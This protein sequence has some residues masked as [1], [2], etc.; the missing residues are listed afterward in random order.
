MLR[1]CFAAVVAATAAASAHRF[2]LRALIVISCNSSA[3]PGSGNGN[4]AEK[5]VSGET[6]RLHKCTLL[7][8]SP[9]SIQT[10]I[11]V[12]IIINFHILNIK[13]ANIERDYQKASKGDASVF[14]FAAC[15]LMIDTQRLLGVGRERG[16][17]FHDCEYAF[18][19][20][21]LDAAST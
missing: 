7:H 3:L 13:P 2:K 14:H 4:H 8:S 1:L 9:I 16:K 12:I 20:G 6:M 21:V 10:H 17:C 5:N 15:S 18:K 11:I 19:T